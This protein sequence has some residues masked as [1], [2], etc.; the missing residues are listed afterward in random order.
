MEFTIDKLDIYI[1]SENLTNH[2]Q[3]CFTYQGQ[4]AVHRVRYLHMSPYDVA[5]VVVVKRGV[6]SFS[7]CS[8]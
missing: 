1:H 5:G 3:K 6:T 4:Q 8:G 7:P 2:C